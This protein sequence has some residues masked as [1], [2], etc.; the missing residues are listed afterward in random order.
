MLQ[1][2]RQ[3]KPMKNSVK[4]AIFPV[5][6]LG[7]R[8]LPATKVMPKEM[9]PIVDMPLI[10]LAVEEAKAAGVERFIFVINQG[11]EML[12]QHFDD[13]PQL[14]EVL[15]KRGKTAQIEIVN[16]ASLPE[17]EPHTAYQ[18]KA[19]GL[20]HAVWC[21]R[22]LIENEAFAVLLPDDFILGAKPCLQQMAAE[23][24][25]TGLNIVAAMEVADADVSKYGIVTPGETNGANTIVKAFVEKPS[26]EEAPSN[27]A[28]IGR[29]IL[30]PEIM[31][32]L[33]RMVQDNATGAG[34][35]IQLTD[36]M[37]QHLQNAAFSAY[38]FEGERFDCGSDIGY[39]KAQ[40]AYAMTKKHLIP[41][42]TKFMMER[43]RQSMKIEDVTKI[44]AA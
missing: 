41:E 15:E 27:L 17:G 32:I 23:F 33:D 26:M 20:G 29:Y 21:A 13:A 4:T 28:V 3:D 12:L 22:N 43:L 9:L 8:L 36:A 37:S 34:G 24:S 42:L 14:M 10:Q 25:R 19:L 30:Q 2:M 31:T 40:I 11:K 18:R 38:E 39:V 6:G 16:A 35:E 7:T 1:D 44:L 5:A